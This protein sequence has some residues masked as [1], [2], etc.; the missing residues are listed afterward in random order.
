MNDSEVL[1]PVSTRRQTRHRRLPQMCVRIDETRNDNRIVKVDP[2][3]GVIGDPLVDFEDSVVLDED[4]A[5]KLAQPCI[6]GDEMTSPQEGSI[7]HPD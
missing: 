3:G 7:T 5:V 2:V 4:I 6:H 1:P